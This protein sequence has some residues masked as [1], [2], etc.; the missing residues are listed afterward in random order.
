[1][2]TSQAPNDKVQIKQMGIAQ[3]ATESLAKLLTQLPSCL[4]FVSSHPAA[5]VSCMHFFLRMR[6]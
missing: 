5:Q 3:Q 4:R 2:A 1:M 6:D